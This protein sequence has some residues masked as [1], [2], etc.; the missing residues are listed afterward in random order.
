MAICINS[1]RSNLVPIK[2]A[3]DSCIP[4]DFVAAVTQEGKTINSDCVNPLQAFVKEWL[5]EIDN[6]PQGIVV[7]PASDSIY[8]AC[9]RA[10]KDDA[11]LLTLKGMHTIL[12]HSGFHAW[13]QP[14][15]ITLSMAKEIF[16]Q[17]SMVKHRAKIMEMDFMWRLRKSL[18]DALVLI[19]VQEG[20]KIGVKEGDNWPFWWD[21]IIEQPKVEETA[22]LLMMPPVMNEVESASTSLIRAAAVPT[23][24]RHNRE[25]ILSIIKLATAPGLGGM[26]VEGELRVDPALKVILGKFIEASQ[27]L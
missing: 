16:M 22:E 23:L 6:A 26:T 24:D 18:G 7:Q 14:R 17:M 3:M 13:M 1:R 15:A 27:T 19:A 21:G 20:L 8:N 9:Q 4:D 5:L 2:A 10:M 25:S 12:R 11:Q